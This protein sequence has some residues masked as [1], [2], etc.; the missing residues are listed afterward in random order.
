MW[1][2]HSRV[3]VQSGIQTGAYHDLY[4]KRVESVSTRVRCPIR[5]G[6][7]SGV[8]HT[9]MYQAKTISYSTLLFIMSVNTN[10]HR[11]RRIPYYAY[12]TCQLGS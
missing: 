1:M 11:N 10:C 2:A 8:Q 12:Y 3:C 4:I 7:T 9:Y 6:V 5:S